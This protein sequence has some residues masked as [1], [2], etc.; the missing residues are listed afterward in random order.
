[1]QSLGCT[2]VVIDPERTQVQT[3]ELLVKGSTITVGLN[4]LTLPG[5]YHV[6][7]RVLSADGHVVTD[8][9][10]FTFAPAGTTS[11]TTGA[12]APAADLDAAPLGSRWPLLAVTAL[13]M[14]SAAAVLLVLRRRG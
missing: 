8:S 7:Y 12:N 6:N 9:R 5:T 10:A 4:V 2:V 1:M 14:L 13:I 3:D 11:A